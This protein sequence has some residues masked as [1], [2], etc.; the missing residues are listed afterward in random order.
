MSPD[1][2]ASVEQ[3]K[4]Q[5][6][7][8]GFRNIFSHTDRPGTQYP[9]HTHSNVTCH[10]VIEGEIEITSGGE[11]KTFR[12]GERFDVPAGEVHSARVG[13]DGCTYILGEK[14]S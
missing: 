9:E 3:I 2:T 13:E 6:R 12:T 1:N 10:V 8:E 14:S 5:L 7:D 4:Q 11:T